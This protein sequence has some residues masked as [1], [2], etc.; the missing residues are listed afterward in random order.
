MVAGL[1]AML[2]TL[3]RDPA[4]YVRQAHAALCL[5][6]V[7]ATGT[8]GAERILTDVLL[9]DAKQSNTLGI[10]GNLGVSENSL[11]PGPFMV[12][13]RVVM[14]YRQPRVMGP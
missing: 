9:R 10:H 12:S 6:L 14:Q 3:S 8:T 7:L 1:F 4:F 11:G 2:S 5:V 13:K